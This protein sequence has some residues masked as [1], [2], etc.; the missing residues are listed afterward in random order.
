[1]LA[2]KAFPLYIGGMRA[3]PDSPPQLTEAPERPDGSSANQ[4]Y[5]D[6]RDEKVR[7]ALDASR[8]APQDRVPQAA[9][10]K[11]FGLEP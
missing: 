6:W 8:R 10:W 2:R 9:V 3:K 11:K 1:M 7:R 4:A 5:L